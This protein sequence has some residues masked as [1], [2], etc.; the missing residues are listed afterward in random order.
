MD[1]STSPPVATRDNQ[2]SITS[3]LLT[4][5]SATNTRLANPF[6]IE[7]I[8]SQ[9]HKSTSPQPPTTL[10]SH[11]SGSRPDDTATP[12]SMAPSQFAPGVGPFASA[13]FSLYNPWMGYLAA[14]SHQHQQQQLQYSSHLSAVVDQMPPADMFFGMPPA[15]MD[16]RLAGLA[17]T[18]DPVHREKLAQLF[19][20]N[21]RDPKLTELLLMGTGGGVDHSVPQS[22]AVDA[23]QASLSLSM[24]SDNVGTIPMH[25]SHMY[26][27]ERSRLMMQHQH[28]QQQHHHHPNSQHGIGGGRDVDADSAE[29]SSD[30]SMTMSPD[31]C[32]KSAGKL[33]WV[34]SI[35]CA[36]KLHLRT[37]ID[38][39]SRVCRFSAHKI[40]N[41]I[42][43]V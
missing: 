7:S 29:S 30:L 27:Q 20:N 17:A 26:L 31:G 23:T 37:V 24:G 36:I 14:A 9:R 21:V 15:G 10:Q 22:A 3:R 2:S 16:P 6:S 11:S 13:N 18:V 5:T 43:A 1:I 40:C 33:N 25:L 8:I 4:S 39:H 28:H 35:N 32:R 12:Q 41:S 19:V 34:C 42:T 38:I